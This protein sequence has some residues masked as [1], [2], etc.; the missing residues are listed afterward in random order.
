MLLLSKMYCSDRS[1]GKEPDSKL[2]LR[3]GVY[4]GFELMQVRNQ[5]KYKWHKQYALLRDML[6]MDFLKVGTV[7]RMS[8]NG[9]SDFA[10]PTMWQ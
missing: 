3:N 7:S 5:N 2:T 9:F 8:T 1:K 10:V 4:W 6:H